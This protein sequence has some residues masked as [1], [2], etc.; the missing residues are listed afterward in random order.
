MS[1]SLDDSIKTRRY[2]H[3]YYEPPQ[4]SRQVK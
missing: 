3:R 2:T 1:L 4:S